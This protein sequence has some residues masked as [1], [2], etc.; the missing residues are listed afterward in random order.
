MFLE[1]LS[2]RHFRNYGIQEVGFAAPKAI[3]V[4]ENAQGKSNLLESIQVLAALKSFRAGRDRD[5]VQGGATMAEIGG[6]CRRGGSQVELAVR[7][8]STG[9]RSLWVNG[10][11][12]RRQREFLGNLHAVLFSSLDLDLVRGGP[13][14]R[15][16]WLDRVLVQLEPIYS[17]LLGQYEQVVRQRNALLRLGEA[18]A[19]QLALWNE[20]LVTLGVRVMRRRSRLLQRL[21]PIA[22][23]WHE[24]ISG[25]EILHVGYV[26]KVSMANND[27]PEAIREQFWVQLAARQM[28]ERMQGTSLVGPHRDDVGLSV[29]GVPARTF[30][31]Q[32]QQ[33]TLV[34]ALKLAELE[35]LTEQLQ[36]TPLL[37]LDDVLAELDLQRQ[38]HLLQAIGDRVQT[39]ITTTHLSTFRGKWLDSAQTFRVVRGTVSIEPI[40]NFHG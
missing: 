3:L 12:V 11:T 4:G 23:R 33:R 22:A 39:V 27:P 38:N 15:R 25:G 35:F 24:A 19:A 2:L 29:N 34:L 32:G 7:L 8:R 26:P 9:G 31:S 30:A 6:V 20:P 28:A 18:A 14:G 21:A 5:L 10:V 17:D 36:E 37:L 40:S 16:E 1:R 13:E